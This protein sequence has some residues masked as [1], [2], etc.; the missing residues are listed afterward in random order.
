[1]HHLTNV[2][3]KSGP[4][5]VPALPKAAQQTGAEPGCLNLKLLTSLLGGPAI[6]G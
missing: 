6:L 1:M 3:T 2:K 4:E 5:R